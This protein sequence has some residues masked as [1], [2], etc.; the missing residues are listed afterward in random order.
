MR[1]YGPC[2]S[3][4]SGYKG[5]GPGNRSRLPVLG[6][7]CL[8]LVEVRGVTRA[9][10]QLGGREGRFRFILASEFSPREVI[11]E[12]KNPPMIFAFRIGA[13]IDVSAYSTSAVNLFI[14]MGLQR[15]PPR[16]VFAGDDSQLSAFLPS[17]MSYRKYCSCHIATTLLEI[18]IY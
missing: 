3:K 11:P 16:K 2:R 4:N 12:A 10:D 13:L 15:A 8:L 14:G 17:P 5:A 9:G 6:V 18:I 1:Y 7:F